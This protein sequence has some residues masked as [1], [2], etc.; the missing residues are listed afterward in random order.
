LTEGFLIAVPAFPPC[1][2]QSRSSHPKTHIS[3]VA[4]IRRLDHKG[5]QKFHL[6]GGGEPAIHGKPDPLTRRQFLAM[7]S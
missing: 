5:R 1:S 4:P 7:N 2:N 6:S 3:P